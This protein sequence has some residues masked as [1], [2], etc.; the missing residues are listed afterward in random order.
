[1]VWVIF[2]RR[3]TKHCFSFATAKIL[4]RLPATVIF[5][6]FTIAVP[7]AKPLSETTYSTD[8]PPIDLSVLES[9]ARR[10]IWT[11]DQHI[12]AISA[13]ADH[14]AS[15]QP[16]IQNAVLML[17]QSC[18]LLSF[19]K[20]DNE[21]VWPH[22]DALLLGWIDTLSHLLA[23]RQQNLGSE[24]YEQ[25]TYDLEAVL[26]HIKI[27]SSPIRELSNP[28]WMA[29]TLI[30]EDYVRLVTTWALRN[31]AIDPDS[32][33][34]SMQLKMAD[35]YVNNNPVRDKITVKNYLAHLWGALKDRSSY[36]DLS[37]Q[38]QKKAEAALWLDDQLWE[39]RL[40]G[41]SEKPALLTLAAV[42]RKNLYPSSLPTEM[43]Q[44][45]TGTVFFQLVLAPSDDVS[46]PRCT[47]MHPVLTPNAHS[48]S[49]PLTQDHMELPVGE[50]TVSA[51][52]PLPPVLMVPAGSAQLVSR[53]VPCST[54]PPDIKTTPDVLVGATIQV[55]TERFVFQLGPAPDEFGN[56]VI[57]ARLL[58]LNVAADFIAGDIRSVLSIFRVFSTVRVDTDSF[59]DRFW[60]AAVGM[61]TALES[62][63]HNDIRVFLRGMYRVHLRHYDAKEGP[64]GN[65]MFGWSPI[66]GLISAGIDLSGVFV[67]LSTTLSHTPWLTVTRPTGGSDTQSA[68][69]WELGG[70]IG[71]VGRNWLPTAQIGIRIGAA[72]AN[73]EDTTGSAR[74]TLSNLRLD[75]RLV[76]AV[77]VMP[78][79]VITTM[80]IDW[81]GGTPNIIGPAFP[82]KLAALSNTFAP[83][84]NIGVG[85]AWCAQRCHNTQFS[86]LSSWECSGNTP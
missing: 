49:I 16:D 43:I 36:G 67:D 32:K 17:E 70:G 80:G 21:P 77:D 31:Y 75:T 57:A 59:V 23:A 46:L 37:L 58:S 60:E 6:Y 25:T 83:T 86:E 53:R 50:W 41:F 35:A 13:L 19:A 10:A 4:T 34:G 81:I 76:A 28:L 1:M 27:R 12:S 15:I 69:N 71:I 51:P 30:H 5:F 74:F 22:C 8:S 73:Y 85:F 54:A 56:Y 44:S 45:D 33:L 24:H 14:S 48:S 42:A 3:C 78:V 38:Q 40:G 68:T 79:R 20:T 2:V 7:F 62:L 26:N 64:I 84:F 52:N 65:D 29:A 18:T 9:A 82:D 55:D 47:E 66:S 63:I 72:W 39:I 11:A 61:N